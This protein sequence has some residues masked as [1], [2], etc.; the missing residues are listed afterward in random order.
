MSG[1]VW[2]MH[3]L[4]H[5]TRGAAASVAAPAVLGRL[6]AMANAHA[7]RRVHRLPRVGMR[8]AVCE[9]IMGL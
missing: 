5:V 6:R 1:R 7:S 2:T 4:A 3:G 8:R 9:P